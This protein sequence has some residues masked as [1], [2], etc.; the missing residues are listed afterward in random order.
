[1]MT[2]PNYLLLSY[3]LGTDLQ[4]D[5]FHHLSRDASQTDWWVVSQALLFS[6]S[7]SGSKFFFPPVIKHFSSCSPLFLKD[8]GEWLSNMCQLPQ[9]HVCIWSGPKDLCVLNLP[10]LSLNTN[11]SS[12]FLQP[13][14]LSLNVHDSWRLAS[15]AKTEAN[16]AFSNYTFS[17]SSITRVWRPWLSGVKKHIAVS[18]PTF[19]AISPSW[20]CAFQSV[21]PPICINIRDC[22]NLGAR[23][24]SWCCWN[25]WD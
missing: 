4:N 3:M 20:Q 2:I 9:T 12:S 25:S 1:M 17:L 6:L 5:L 24:C 14:P 15:A 13:S 21:H 23:P 7:K 19:H 22:L 11:K 18:Y 16:K 8:D 10:S